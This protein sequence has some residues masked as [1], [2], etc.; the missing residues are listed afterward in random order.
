MKL[1]RDITE[2]RRT[3]QSLRAAGT[4]LSVVPTMGA[5]HEG[6]LELIRTAARHS[7]CVITTVFVNPAQFGKGEDFDRYPRNLEQDVARATDAGSGYVFAPETAAMYLPDHRTTV[8]VERLDA[9][10]E[11]RSRPG[12]F[13]GVATVV[14]KLFNITHPHVAV[15]GQKDAQQVVIIR[16]MIDELN[17]GIE[18]VVVPVVREPDGL[19]MSSRNVYLTPAQR[20]EAPVLYRALQ[21]AAQQIRAGRKEGA[22]VIRETE[23]LIRQGSSGVVD[24]V[25]VADAATL[26]EQHILKSGTT[27]LVS[28]AVRFGPTRLI[29]NIL[30]TVP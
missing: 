18:L 10:L 13:R 3:A 25:S 16:R 24:Y 20:S 29:D 15:F 12:H 8:T 21:Q 11:G 14:T 1:I 6:H 2:M 19:A 27:L 22:T 5:L 30:V 28:L 7:D 17:Y 9:L 4:R 23:S 26:D